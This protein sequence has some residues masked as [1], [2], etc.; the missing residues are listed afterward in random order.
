MV[1]EILTAIVSSVPWWVRLSLALIFLVFA[2]IV[3]WYA[4]VRGGI[5][6]GAIGFVFLIFSSR[7]DSEKNGY[8]F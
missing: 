6:L 2:A 3:F 1:T 5:L 7:S 8:K 4:S